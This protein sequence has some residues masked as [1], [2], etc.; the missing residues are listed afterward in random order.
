MGPHRLELSFSRTRIELFTL[1][2]SVATLKSE[3]LTRK[4]DVTYCEEMFSGISGE[5]FT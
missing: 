4:I 5:L 2:R 1:A 3:K